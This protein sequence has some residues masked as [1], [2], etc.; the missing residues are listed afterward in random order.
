L[1]EQFIETG[2]CNHSDAEHDAMSGRSGERMTAADLTADHLGMVVL[3]VPGIAGWEQHLLLREVERR[4]GKVYV[5]LRWN[6]DPSPSNTERGR[7]AWGSHVD[8]STPIRV[9]PPPRAL[10]ADPSEAS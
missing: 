7:F 10:R 2:D 8:P 6:D 4:D 3:D 5:A 9:L 1:C